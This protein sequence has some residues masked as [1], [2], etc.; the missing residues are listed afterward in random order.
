M[1]TRIQSFSPF[2]QTQ[3]SDFIKKKSLKLKDRIHYTHVIKTIIKKKDQIKCVK[4]DVN[5]RNWLESV[6]ARQKAQFS[7]NAWIM[8]ISKPQ[9]SLQKYFCGPL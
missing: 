1:L 8:H 5:V 7:K 2:Q 9:Y 3:S 6:M 4:S